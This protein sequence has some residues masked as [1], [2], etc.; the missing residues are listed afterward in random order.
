MKTGMCMGILGGG[1][2]PGSPNMTIYQTKKCHFSHSFSDLAS[3]IH[4]R[5]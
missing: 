1:V 3:K 5:Y 2:Q 4:T